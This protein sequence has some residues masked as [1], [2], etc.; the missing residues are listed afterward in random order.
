MSR[1]D[2]DRDYREGW[3]NFSH[4][5]DRGFGGTRAGEICRR[6][7]DKAPSHR[8]SEN[9]PGMCLGAAQENRKAPEMSKKAIDREPG[10]LYC[11]LQGSAFALEGEL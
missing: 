1:E 7:I 2:V 6:I 11:F 10:S 5:A 4:H 3:R 8:Q 9:M